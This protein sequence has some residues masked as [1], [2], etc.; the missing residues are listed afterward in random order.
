MTNREFYLQR[1]EA[2]L[3]AFLKVLKALPKDQLHYKPHD[4]SPSAEQIVWLLT[5]ELQSCI[6]V[7]MEKKTERPSEPP[8]PFDQML[9]MFEGSYRK[10]M[11]VV[12]KMNDPEWNET[13][14]FY[15]NGKVISE[16]PISQFLWLILFDS[17]H[18]RGQLTAYLRPMG[19]KVPA[20]YGPSGDE[21]P[22]QP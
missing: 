22:S 21:R 15:F 20:V 6:D 7:A 16:Q 19:G 8:P 13:A 12:S 14:K 5:F 9:E 4:R 2:E 3:P 10:L 11:D 18:H 17:V 1:R